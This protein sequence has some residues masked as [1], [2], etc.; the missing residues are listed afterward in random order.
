MKTNQTKSKSRAGRRPAAPPLIRSILV[1]VDFSRPSEKALD[2]AASL[3]G[4]FGAK[5]ILLNVVEPFPT[6]DF[7]YSPMAL[8]D[9]ALVAQ[10]KEHLQK[11]L[12]R[13]GLDA[14]VVEKILVR[15]GSPYAE[16]TSAARTLKVDL[17]VISTHGYTGLA[18]VFMGS[19]SERVVR[20]APCPVLVVRATGRD[21][22]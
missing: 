7:A 5:L 8:D 18:H 12:A 11:V 13:S 3:A 22:K 17:I 20:H 9:N 6:P 21:F 14:S 16:I 19:T 2:Y 15:H 10:A 1:P 4:S